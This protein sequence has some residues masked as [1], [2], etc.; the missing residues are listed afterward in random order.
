[1]KDNIKRLEAFEK[2]KKVIESC[3][4]HEHLIGADNMI[5]GYFLIYGTDVYWEELTV[6]WMEACGENVHEM[7]H[8]CGKA[9]QQPNNAEEQMNSH[10]ADIMMKGMHLFLL[11]I[12]FSCT[13]E[14]KWYYRIE[15]ITPWK[16]SEPIVN[17]YYDFDSTGY[18]NIYPHSI[19]KINKIQL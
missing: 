8:P 10:I 11:L 1:M 6:M 16:D 18:R 7:F 17:I 4:T 2:V 5:D 19:V 9:H 12:L 14:P 13:P 3:E 15:V